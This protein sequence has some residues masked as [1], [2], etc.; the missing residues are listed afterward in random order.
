MGL[1]DVTGIG[2]GLGAFSFL[3]FL[4]V[5]PLFRLVLEQLSTPGRLRL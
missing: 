2:S 3:F 4:D 5:A 1:W